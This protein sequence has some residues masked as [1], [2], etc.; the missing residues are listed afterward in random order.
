MPALRRTKQVPSTAKE[1][2]T[3]SDR[4]YE[5]KCSQVLEYQSP[6]ARRPM[7]G[8]PSNSQH[9]P[10]KEEESILKRR[11]NAFYSDLFGRSA[12][13]DDPEATMSARRSKGRASHE[14][15]LIVHQDWSDCRTELLPGARRGGDATPQVRRSEELH[16]AT[17]AAQLAR[18]FGEESGSWKSPNK[19]EAVSHD[20]SE[21]IKYSD[22]MSTRQ[23]Q[24][25]HL[26]ATL[27]ADDFYSKA[28]NIKEWE[29]I[30]LHL[31]G[32]PHDADD[33]RSMP[34]GVGDVVSVAEQDG[35]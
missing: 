5:Q 16:Q 21:K 31:S 32:L 18:I 28:C 4:A 20:N 7:E 8:A 10:R 35:S 11:A 13:Y 23:I 24:Q 19:L 12:A 15:H 25:G 33:V 3:H 17:A 30:E 34:C 1:A 26:K 2:K 27:Q 22:G 29:V 14:E 9:A 6:E